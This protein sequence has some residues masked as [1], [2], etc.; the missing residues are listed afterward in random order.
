MDE[1]DFFHLAIL[2]DAAPIRIAMPISVDIVSPPRWATFKHRSHQ[3]RGRG[4]RSSSN[5]GS[6]TGRDGGGAA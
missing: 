1:I 5:P 6:R 3:L 2:S 4:S